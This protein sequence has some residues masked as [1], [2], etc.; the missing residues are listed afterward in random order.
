MPLNR[1]PLF[2]IS[3]IGVISLTVLAWQFRFQESG[4]AYFDESSLDSWTEAGGFGNPRALKIVDDGILQIDSSGPNRAGTKR[5]WLTEEAQFA[6]VQIRHRAPGELK[7]ISP[8]KKYPLLIQLAGYETVGAR[9]LEAPATLDFASPGPDWETL[10]TVIPIPEGSKFFTL[11]I[12]IL[13]NEGSYQI[14]GIEVTE[15]ETRPWFIPACVILVGLWAGW[16]YWAIQRGH[17]D[18]SPPRLSSFLATAWILIW[19]SIL[20]FPRPI[21]IP[22]PF[23]QT[24][25][26]ASSAIKQPGTRFIVEEPKPKTDSTPKENRKADTRPS[27]WWKSLLSWFKA[28]PGGRFL[29][30]FGVIGL[31]A[32][33]LFLITSP[34]QGL[35]FVIAVTIGTEL[36]PWLWL[37]DFESNDHLDLLAY[38]SATLVAIPIATRLKNRLTTLLQEPTAL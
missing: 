2:W 34:R 1:Q 27:P 12:S 5:S 30:H 26:T 9:F 32:G 10:D 36:V 13:S 15:V 22:R 11:I 16:I 18:S 25:N 4:T 38:V 8:A 31:F 6:K 21:D 29:I 35:P 24:F 14:S 19:G 33:I 3:L 37:G 7:Q 20:V 17:R 23:L 28:H